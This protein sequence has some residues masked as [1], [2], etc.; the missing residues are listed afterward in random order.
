MSRPEP[1]PT[2]ITESHAMR[3]SLAIERGKRLGAELDLHA[4]KLV[5]K[6]A[7][8]ENHKL[9]TAAL[10]AEIASIYEIVEGDEIIL[11]TLQIKRAPPPPPD[12]GHSSK[13]KDPT[14]PPPPPPKSPDWIPSPAGVV[15][16]LAPE[17]R[18]K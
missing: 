11:D 15:P 16:A 17:V 12:G 8:L 2:E 4:L 10:Q 3:L 7:E 14:P 9:N 5:D 18:P 6:R 1:K 13:K